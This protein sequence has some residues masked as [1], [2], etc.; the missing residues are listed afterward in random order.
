MGS[1]IAWY[2]WYWQVISGKNSLISG[3][4]FPKNLRK[5]ETDLGVVLQG[6]R[7]FVSLRS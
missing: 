4:S 6:R 7:C 1:N 5:G 3:G 2:L